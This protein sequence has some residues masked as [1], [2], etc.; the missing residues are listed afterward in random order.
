MNITTYIFGDLSDGYTQYPDDYTSEILSVVRDRHSAETMLCIHRDGDLMYY[1]YVR[2]LGEDHYVG[3]AVVLNDVMFTELKR[4]FSLF[5]EF[6]AEIAIRG[7]IIQLSEDGNLTSTIGKL[8]ENQS[9]VEQ[10]QKRLK[11]EFEKMEGD[12]Q[13]LP[14]VNYSVAKGEERFFPFSKADEAVVEASHTY[15]NTYIFK[16]EDF[17]SVSL[18]NYRGVLR[19]LNEKNEALQKQYDELKFEYATVLRK[20]KQIT[21]VVL[22]GVGLTL[23]VFI[24]I[25]AFGNLSHTK[26]QLATSKSE[27]AESRNAADKL[28]GDNSSLKEKLSEERDANDELQIMNENIK[29]NTYPLFI[30]KVYFL[31]VNYNNDVINDDEDKFYV[32][33][34]DY[35]SPQLDYISFSDYESTASFKLVLKGPMEDEY[36]HTIRIKKG[37]NLV[38]LPGRGFTTWKPGDYT[39]EIWYH[40]GE[41]GFTIYE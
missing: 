19:A 34:M 39:V 26:T 13:K 32:N 9:L 1:G 31:N 33:R 25:F 29:N 28:A 36:T 11:D 41:Q 18:G 37:E 14:A 8:Y 38:T 16:D 40:V 15:T 4:V 24:L 21:Q 12:T 27:L 22:L 2:S 20:K 7:E 5:E 6:I 3:L 10:I 30:R 23:C 17:D 35:L